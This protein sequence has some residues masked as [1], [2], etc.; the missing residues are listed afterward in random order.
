[1]DS[2]KT[3]KTIRFKL[4]TE[5]QNSRIRETI[6]HLKNTNF[7]LANFVANLG[8]FIDDL[9]EFLYKYSKKDDD[10]YLNELLTLKSLWVKTY[11]KAEYAER[12]RKDGYTTRRQQHTIADYKV[13]SIIDEKIEQ[14]DTVYLELCDDASA[15][16]NERAKRART[17]LLLKSLYAK[18]MLPSLVDLVE[19]I[20]DKKEKGNIGLRLKSNAR[21]LMAQLEAGIQMYLPEQS[22]G[23]VIAKASLNYYTINKTPIDYE[24]KIKEEVDRLRT[25]SNSCPLSRKELKKA[26]LQDISDKCNGKP[27]CLGDSPF[28]EEGTYVSLR[29]LLKNILAQQKAKFSEM[30]Q[31]DTSYRKLKNSNLYLFRYIS[32]NEFEQYKDLTDSIEEISTKKNN[33]INDKQKEALQ[34]KLTH[35]KKQRGALINEADRNTKEYFK[36]YKSFANWY[37]DI[38]LKHGKILARLKSIEKERVESQMLQYWAVIAEDNLQH[39]LI[40]IPKEYA[41]ECHRY[42]NTNKTS[43]GRMNL[44]WF[45]SFTYRSLQK[46]CFGNLDSG[47]NSFNQRLKSELSEYYSYL[48]SGEHEFKGDEQK[49]IRFYKDVLKSNHAERSLGLPKQEIL[50]NVILPSF[51]S[52]DDFK[53]ALEKVCYRRFTCP[54]PSVLRTLKSK[55]NAQIFNITSLDLQN[56]EAQKSQESRFEHTDKSHTQLW[57]EFWSEKNTTEHFNIRLNPEL[58]ITYRKAKESRVQ[59]YGPNSEL[60]DPKKKNRYLHDQLTLVTTLSEHCLSYSVDQAFTKVEEVANNIKKF[61]QKFNRHDIR[62]AFGIDNGEV[63]LST[64]GIYLPQFDQPTN[65]EKVQM[66]QQTEEYGFKVLQITNLSYSEPDKNGKERR[67]LQNPSYFLNQDLYCRTFGKTESEYKDMFA[68]N[69]QEQHTLSLDLS[70]AKVINGHIV[71]NGDVTSLFNLWMRHAQ[72]EIYGMNEHAKRKGAK[73][74]TLKKS[75]ELTPAERRKFIEYLIEGTKGHEKY[76]DLTEAE[77]NEY[78]SWVYRKWSFQEVK[79]NSSY[80][81]I[82]SK[83]RVR[84]NYLHNVLMAVSFMGEEL[85][86]V[87]DIFNIRNI[88][89]LRKDFYCV[90]SEDEILTNI[91][92][93]NKRIISNEELD[94]KFNQIKASL[95]ANVV[96]VIDFLYK[97][98]KER[99]DG[100]GII[101]IEDFCNNK[102]EKAREKFAGNI[103]RMLERKLYLKFLNYGLVPPVKNILQIR[104]EHKLKQIGNIRFVDEAGTSQNCPVCETGRLNH[105]DECS[106]Q[107]GFCSTGIMHSNDGIAGFNIAKRGFTQKEK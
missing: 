85:V 83:H 20:T 69:F 57:K 40:L 59:K 52:L 18:H 26:I 86:S 2:I 19:N 75:N 60:H 38:A 34:S 54:D 71:T 31:T 49:K 29:Q 105:T 12:K 8:T 92:A 24:K 15:E 67:L 58:S 64:L 1:M 82:F 47:S 98:Y 48:K 97:Q 66:L 72:R 100:E 65:T 74:I 62:F 44:H 84:G 45:E 93:Y 99:F 102:V 79:E 6:E 78:V 51:D 28:M 91:N 107:C 4:H 7:Q 5:E 16:L 9:N 3:T 53:V 80:E 41:Q 101:A 77:K 11:A 25:D 21:H 95:V 10:F 89:K 23:F 39:Q 103:Y 94:L 43:S 42:L 68:A 81:N 14:I 56:L 46:L 22:Q 104:D 90:K 96:G 13:A 61:N 17:G 73:N 36:E 50:Q 27:L 32:E 33:A 63:E 37:R 106:D 35:L 70:T 30:M 55:Y 76:K 88:F 87:K